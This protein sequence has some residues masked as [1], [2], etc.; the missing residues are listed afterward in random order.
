MVNDYLPF[1]L[2]HAYHDCLEFNCFRHKYNEFE[3]TDQR[4][5]RL[6]LWVFLNQ[7]YILMILHFGLRRRSKEYQLN[8]FISVILYS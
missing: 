1:L 8:L 2:L 3:Y 6:V 5:E 4:P 7:M